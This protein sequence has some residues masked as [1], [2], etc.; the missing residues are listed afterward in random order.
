MS[1]NVWSLPWCFLLHWLLFY[2]SS[3]A[4]VKPLSVVKDLWVVLRTGELTLVSGPWSN[5]N[6]LHLSSSIPPRCGVCHPFLSQ[7]SCILPADAFSMSW[8]CFCGRCVRFPRIAHKE[9]HCLSAGYLLCEWKLF[10][11]VFLGLDLKLMWIDVAPL[12]TM[13]LQRFAPAEGLKTWDSRI[14]IPECWEPCRPTWNR[15][16][17]QVLGVSEKLTLLGSRCA[18]W[19]QG[20][21]EQFIDFGSETGNICC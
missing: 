14:E 7:T 11:V 15:C 1:V 18:G 17:L 10:T 6:I 8:L 9:R 5:D 21:S 3:Q 13:E 4:A 19:E 16:K 20:G 12:K 2:A